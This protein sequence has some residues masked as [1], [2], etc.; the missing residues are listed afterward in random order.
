VT[1]P[2]DR[3]LFLVAA[4]VTPGASGQ[5]G[6]GRMAWWKLSDSFFSMHT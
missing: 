1:P 2:P 5:F 3:P 4:V 6:Y